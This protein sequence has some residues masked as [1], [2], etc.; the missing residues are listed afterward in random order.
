MAELVFEDHLG[1]GTALSQ[2]DLGYG[3]FSGRERP[4]EAQRRPRD[5]CT[6]SRRQKGGLRLKQAAERQ[7]QDVARVDLGPS[8]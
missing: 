6:L 2:D 7:K 5:D 3:P 8:T 4:Q 1:P